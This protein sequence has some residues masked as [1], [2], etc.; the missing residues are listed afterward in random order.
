MFV[1]IQKCL[2]RKKK[3][4]GYVE[5]RTEAGDMSAKSWKPSIIQLGIGYRIL[6]RKNNH[7]EYYSSIRKMDKYRYQWTYAKKL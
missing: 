3:A 1:S 5:Y 6:Y 7:S 2:D 4:V